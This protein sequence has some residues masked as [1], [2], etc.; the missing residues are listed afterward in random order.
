[1]A[2]PVTSRRQAA[3]KNSSSRALT[4]V[5]FVLFAVGLIH[6]VIEYQRAGTPP[7]FCLHCS[8]RATPSSGS[9]LSAFKLAAWFATAG[10]L[11]EQYKRRQVPINRWFRKGCLRIL[12]F[13]RIPADG[14]TEMLVGGIF[15]IILL[16][17]GMVGLWSGTVR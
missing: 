2:A 6:L 4:L 17:L 14:T 15:F 7:L 3:P 1:M 16:L 8:Y 9:A 10:W 12:A 13:Y 5:G 11:L